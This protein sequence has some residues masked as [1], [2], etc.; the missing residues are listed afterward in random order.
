MRG[1]AAVLAGAAVW[2][3]VSGWTPSV[4][5]RKPDLPSAWAVPAALATGTVAGLLA[6]G[7]LA[8]PTASIAIA[9]LAASVPITIDASRRR[10]NRESLAEAWPDFLALLKGRVAAGATLP[11]A[12]IAA[13]RRSPEPLT[14]SARHVEESVMFGDGFTPALE[15]L[16]HELDD[17][18]S[19]RVLATL[20]FAHRSGG[21]RV[22][23]VISSLGVSV[24]DELR[25]RRAHAAALTEQRMTATVALVAPWAL[26]AL[27][28]ATNPQA[29]DAY[30]TATGSMVIAIGFASTGLG[31]IAARRS[32]RLSSAPRVVR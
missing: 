9:V 31:F 13:A 32:A 4:Q 16:Q 11:D 25:L 10:R 15:R 23:N 8:V 18:T 27:T 29:A 3:V 6:L 7:L 17:A 22:G 12:F 28:I 19:D 14:S 30:R 26:L 5:L 20:S 21:H 24:S 1:V 2:I